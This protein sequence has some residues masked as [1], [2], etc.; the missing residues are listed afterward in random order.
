MV[1]WL[2]GLYLSHFS[3]PHNVPNVPMSPRGGWIAWL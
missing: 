3:S 2:P 1:Q